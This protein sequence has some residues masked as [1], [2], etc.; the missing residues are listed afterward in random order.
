[1]GAHLISFTPCQALRDLASETEKVEAASRIRMARQAHEA[2]SAKMA[3]DC[4]SETQ[5]REIRAKRQNLDFLEKYK[6]EE[7]A[8]MEMAL[9]RDLKLQR[10]KMEFDL[11]MLE[12]K[13]K[14]L[15]TFLHQLKEE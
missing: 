12:N 7:H 10:K 4:Q 9:E 13:D 2:Q 5:E 14:I 15:L 11:E 6:K 1:M 8:C 3:L